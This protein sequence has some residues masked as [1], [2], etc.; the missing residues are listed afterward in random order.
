MRV[1]PIGFM[2]IHDQ[3]SSL[4]SELLHLELQLERSVVLR[5]SFS[6]YILA[7]FKSD[8]VNVRKHI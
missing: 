6:V 2:M 5:L 8:C 1:F 7:L 4:Y 3:M